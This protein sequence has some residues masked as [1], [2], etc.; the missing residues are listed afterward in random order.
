MRT[1]NTLRN[2]NTDR[3]TTDAE[4]KERLKTTAPRMRL[5]KLER[6]K[7]DSKVLE[8]TYT[9]FVEIIAS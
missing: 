3:K 9:G 5:A 2:R 6:G 4:R 8:V 7:Q 1:R